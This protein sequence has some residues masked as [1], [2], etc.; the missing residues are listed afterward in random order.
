[1]SIG[2]GFVKM[3]THVVPAKKLHVG[4]KVPATTIQLVVLMKQS[5]LIQ[6]ATIHQL[7]IMIQRQD[8]MTA[9]AN[10]TLARLRARVTL[11]RM[12]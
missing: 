2:M 10:M 12:E 8:V 5:A 7:A 3:L 11:I 1:M 4:T 9:A 6:G